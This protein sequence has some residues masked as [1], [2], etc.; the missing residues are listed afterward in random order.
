MTGFE[1]SE[2]DLGWRTELM[3]R[4]FIELVYAGI[5]T[6]FGD[7][8]IKKDVDELIFRHINYKVLRIILEMSNGLFGSNSLG[9]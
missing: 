3:V 5:R 2:R 9:L 7:R 8:T 4:L 6:A 1:G